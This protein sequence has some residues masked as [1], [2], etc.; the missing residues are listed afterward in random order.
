MENLTATTQELQVCQQMVMANTM[1][2][3]AD[4]KEMATMRAHQEEMRAAISTVRSTQA[5]FKVTFS[6]WIGGILASND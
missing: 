3:R 1:A 4:Q 5:N 2:T 6:K